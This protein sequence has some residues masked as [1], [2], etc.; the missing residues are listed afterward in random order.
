MAPVFV[1]GWVAVGDSLHEAGSKGIPPVGAFV[2]QHG[3]TEGTPLPRSLEDQFAVLPGN[4]AIP[5]RLAIV[6]STA[7]SRS[8]SAPAATTTTAT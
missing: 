7:I 3:Q 1:V 2:V 6:G 5:S 8:P 4:A